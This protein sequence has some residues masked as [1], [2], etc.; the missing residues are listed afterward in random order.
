[1]PRAARANRER[2]KF[3]AAHVYKR[4]RIMHS[5]SRP[6]HGASGQNSITR[7]D[8]YPGFANGAVL[9]AL[10]TGSSRRNLLSS[11]YVRKKN[12]AF[13]FKKSA[14]LGFM[15]FAARGVK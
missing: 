8:S 11:A 2:V 9:L 3:R 10:C 15:K 4:A 5:S 7:R 6:K 12:R 14:R 1:M 13:K